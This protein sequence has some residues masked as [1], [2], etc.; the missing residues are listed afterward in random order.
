MSV[1]GTHILVAG[2][3]GYIQGGI[4]NI[5]VSHPDSIFFAEEYHYPDNFNMA[6]F[7]DSIG[8]AGYFHNDILKLRLNSQGLLDSIGHVDTRAGVFSIDV[9]GDFLYAADWHDDRL[10]IFDITDRRLPTEVSSLEIEEAATVKVFG[11]H[12]FVG[13]GMAEI[14]A[15]DISQPDMPVLA[16]E[17]QITGSSALYHDFLLWHDL[18]FA[19]RQSDT[20]EIYDFSEQTFDLIAQEKVYGVGEL[21]IRDSILYTGHDLLRINPDTTLSQ[22]SESGVFEYIFSAFDLVD[23]IFLAA[24]GYNGLGLFN[25]ADLSEPQ[26]ITYWDTL[27]SSGEPGN[28]VDVVYFD[29]HAYLLDGSWGITVLDVSDPTAP[30]FAERITTPGSAQGLVFDEEYFYVA[31]ERGIEIFS[32]ESSVDVEDVVEHLPQPFRLYQNYPNPFNSTTVIPYALDRPTEVT[33]GIYNVLGQHVKTLHQGRQPAGSY[34]VTW[35]GT[36]QEG[37]NVASGVYFY[38]L[39]SPMH[40]ETMKMLSLR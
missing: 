21:Q 31:D 14:R 36:S 28:G 1:A 5:D 13:T 37:K 8:I 16:D 22:L 29:G 9:Y 38:T 17:K 18:L 25:L 27:S 33:L 4:A 19:G 11:D 12:L 24:S 32:Y 35:D 34:Q 15:Y 7:A 30:F 3:G 10:R 39:R 40:S 26:F 20:L 23:T 2:S 6:V